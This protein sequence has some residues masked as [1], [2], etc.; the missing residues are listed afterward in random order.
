MGKFSSLVKKVE[1]FEK[2]SLYGDRSSFLKAIGQ[3]ASDS[4]Q[5]VNDM[6]AGTVNS[7]AGAIQNWI[8]NYAEKQPDV[9]GGA[10]AGLPP[11][12]RNPVQVIRAA[13]ANKTFDIDTLPSIGTAA[14]DLA[15]V[16]NLGN[17]GSNAKNAWM[18][19]VFPVASRLI[20]LVPKQMQYLRS[21]I[22]K[23]NPQ[24]EGGTTT[25]PEVAI[26]GTLPKKQSQA[27]MA[28]N[29]A[30]SVVTKANRLTE[31]PTRK[32]QLQDL[33]RSISTLKSL[34]TLFKNRPAKDLQEHFARME[35]SEAL[36]Q[37]YN[38][39][40]YDDLE[41]V[42]SLDFGRGIPEMG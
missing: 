19:L 16:N 3:D 20:D 1:L 9:A 40:N 17:M 14:R 4:L 11:Q 12:M 25:L 8:A 29:L 2:L 27:E 31:G 24:P 6:L 30:K 5:P 10:I 34:D 18:K 13:A 23:Y 33:D 15:A 35:I 42:R 32:T 36:K 7:L 21:H 39:L 26:E 37:V 41:T 22:S 28:R 38:M